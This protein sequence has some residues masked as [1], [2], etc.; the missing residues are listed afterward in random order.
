M[1]DH[2]FFAAMAVGIP[3]ITPPGAILMTQLKAFYVDDMPT[4]YAAATP[5]EAARLYEEDVGDPCDD[6]YPREV[7][8]AELDQSIP[9]FGEDEQPTGEMTTMRVWLEEAS[10][11]FLCGAE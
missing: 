5:E 2:D 1:T 8:A 10:P 9:E 4:I 3:P 7:S 6:G 11:G